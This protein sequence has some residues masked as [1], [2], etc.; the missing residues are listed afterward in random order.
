VRR[1]KTNFCFKKKSLQGSHK[2]REENNTRREHT[3]RIIGKNDKKKVAAW[4][5][6]LGKTLLKEAW[7][8]MQ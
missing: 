4:P 8:N 3:L 2:L 5:P 1:E 7:H 6:C